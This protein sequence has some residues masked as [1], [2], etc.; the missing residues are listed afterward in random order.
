MQAGSPEQ[1]AAF[2][3]RELAQNAKVV[4]FAGIGTE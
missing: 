2:I 3:R 4:R 1:F